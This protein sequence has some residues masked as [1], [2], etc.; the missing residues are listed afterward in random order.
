VTA[1]ISSELVRN[2]VSAWGDDG[3]RWL[4]A[5]PAILDELAGAWNLAIGA[6]F[7]LSYHYVAAVTCGDG[8]PAVLKL[9]VPDGGSLATEA[10][11]LAAFGGQGAGRLLRTDV[12]AQLIAARR[13]PAE[14]AALIDRVEAN[15]R[16]NVAHLRQ[17]LVG[18]ADLREV[19]Q[20][21][22]PDGLTFEPAR[23]PD[24]SRQIWKISGNADLAAVM[25]GGWFR[26]ESDL[27]GKVRIQDHAPRNLSRSSR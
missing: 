3:A 15:V 5:L 21:M 23:T 11:P 20:A 27:N 1:E 2:I 17:A 19:F 8:T 18:Q 6:P 9:G 25:K 13:T 12:E 10:R 4:A 14:L 24:G 26:L 7:Q 22:F 16:T